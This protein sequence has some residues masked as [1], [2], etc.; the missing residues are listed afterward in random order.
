MDLW[1]K[2]QTSAENVEK[3]CFLGATRDPGRVRSPG[4]VLSEPLVPLRASAQ[5]PS[6][7]AEREKKQLLLGGGK[8]E[9][10]KDMCPARGCHHRP[11]TGLPMRT[12]NW[13]PGSGR[14][15][16][17]ERGKPPIPPGCKQPR[18]EWSSTSESSPKP[19]SHGLFSR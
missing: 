12:D 14:R 3:Q 5:I 17:R 18:G 10:E 13:H 16:R 2:G 8:S 4:A 19:I 1:E 7:P 6:F 15:A 9:R 11:R